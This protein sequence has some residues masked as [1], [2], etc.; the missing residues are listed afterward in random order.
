MV[1]TARSGQIA[2]GIEY[3]ESFDVSS[4]RVPTLQGTLTVAIPT[5]R[6]LLKIGVVQHRLREGVQ[7]E[8]LDPATRM[9]VVMLSTLA[10]VV[11]KAPDWWYDIKR[12]AHQRES[13]RTAAPELIPDMDLLW[14]IYGRYVAFSDSFPDRRR[15]PSTG[16]TAEGAPTVAPGADAQHASV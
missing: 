2:L 12:D 13:D 8:E 3:T 6:D 9:T 10:V 16:R 1:D 7:I 5:G 14:D 15:D 4:K 11:R